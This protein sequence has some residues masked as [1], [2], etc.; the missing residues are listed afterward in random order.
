MATKKPVEKEKSL[1]DVTKENKK[2]NVLLAEQSTKL[3]GI[4]SSQQFTNVKL[5]NCLVS[6]NFI[7]MDYQTPK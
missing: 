7:F 1:A 6:F 5:E 3:T 2:Q 4:K